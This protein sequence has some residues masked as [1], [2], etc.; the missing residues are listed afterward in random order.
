MKELTPFEEAPAFFILLGAVS[1]DDDVVSV[2]VV[3]FGFEWR[4]SPPR[5]PSSTSIF[6][7]R[8]EKRRD[9]VAVARYGI[10]C[11]R[12]SKGKQQRANDTFPPNIAQHDLTLS[13]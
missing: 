10:R 2:A 1:H 3:V 9:L 8:N 11:R 6:A 7:R 12:G 13:S 4:E 5:R